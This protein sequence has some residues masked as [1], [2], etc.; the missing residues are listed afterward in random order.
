MRGEN[1]AK[2]LFDTDVND[3]KETG[4]QDDDDLL[5]CGGRSYLDLTI[6]DTDFDATSLSSVVNSALHFTA[7]QKQRFKLRD[8]LKMEQ[9]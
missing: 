5:E 1:D 9:D 2:D 6:L 4:N 7:E 3:A 8:Y